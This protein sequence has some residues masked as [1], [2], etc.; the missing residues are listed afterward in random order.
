MFIKK[1]TVAKKKAKKAKLLIYKDAKDHDARIKAY[2]DNQPIVKPPKTIYELVRGW[3]RRSWRT[4]RT[5]CCVSCALPLRFRRAAVN[6]RTAYGSGDVFG[7]FDACAE[8]QH[9]P[10][11][12]RTL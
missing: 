9:R 8:P 10:A 3:L 1:K 12:F 4:S 5:R 6:H 7:M 11:A 2:G